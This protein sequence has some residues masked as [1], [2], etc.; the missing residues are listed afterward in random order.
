MKILNV[1]ITK[2]HKHITT[3]L[4]FKTDLSII[5]GVNGSGKTH[6]LNLI[7]ATLRLD[8]DYIDKISFKTFTLTFEKEN[9]TYTIN[10]TKKKNKFNFEIND[11]LIQIKYS[12]DSLH[13]FQHEN[14][15]TIEFVKAYNNI[16]SS[17]EKSVFNIFKR[18]SRPL[19][20][21]LNRQVN[22]ENDILN[23]QLNNSERYFISNGMKRSITKTSGI[24]KNSISLCKDLIFSE[25]KN[26]RK[27]EETQAS[28]LRNKIISSSFNYLDG[29][30]LSSKGMGEKLR[31]IL[32]S[33]ES[34]IDDLDKMN[35]SD[36]GMRA[37]IE[38]FYEKLSHIK[39]VLNNS[40]PDSNQVTLE[41][42]LNISQ[43]DR[44]SN[45]I[46]IINEHKKTMDMKKEKLTL[47]VNTVNKF[48]EYT[49]KK[50]LINPVGGIVVIINEKI[51]V[52]LDNLSS[53]EKQLITII[54]NMVFC[55]NQTKGLVIM[56]DEPEISL[57][58][59][60]QEIFISTLQDIRRDAQLILATHSPDIINDNEI[61]CMPIINSELVK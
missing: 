44:V 36:I 20:L 46:S 11:E 38:R 55:K 52:S 57:H 16:T 24:E 50:I 23:E 49:G 2:L 58:I 35:I 59:R 1:R 45:I 17:N 53:G 60:W 56:I 39:E 5:T 34:I 14:N 18:I 21:G 13:V 47:F 15:L 3:N 51:R 12:E 4:D 29:E 48:F 25:N 42:L 61:N 7:D 22:H 9:T 41:L 33:K 10:I 30:L 54:A 6:I 40:N 32:K 43:I 31:S 37:Q 19:Y 26:I 8:I 28:L 27:Y